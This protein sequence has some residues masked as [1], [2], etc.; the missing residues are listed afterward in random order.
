MAKI[1]KD[2]KEINKI[3]EKQKSLNRCRQKIINNLMIKLLEKEKK[4]IKLKR[5]VEEAKFVIHHLAMK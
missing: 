3:I 1:F 2:L 5:E 4:N